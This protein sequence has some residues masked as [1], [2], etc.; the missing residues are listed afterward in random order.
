MG[1][2]EDI[3]LRIRQLVKEEVNK[4]L[5]RSFVESRINDLI[6]SAM[7]KFRYDPGQ[8]LKKMVHDIMLE[9]Y[10]ELIEQK[11]DEIKR[12][13]E[14]R[15]EDIEKAV[16]EEFDYH[17]EDIARGISLRADQA[18]R[19]LFYGKDPYDSDANF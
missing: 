5:T 18:I 7:Q 2:S 6:D 15:H 13:I 14:S 10:R 11:K 4:R 9:Q 3:D 17:M 1:F 16:Q 12:L 19:H 8:L